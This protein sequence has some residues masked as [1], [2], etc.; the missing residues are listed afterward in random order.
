MTVSH[1]SDK[2]K[3]PSPILRWSLIGGGTVSLGLGIAGTI[4][5][6]LPTT[7][8]LLLSAACYARSSQR[9]YAWLLNHRVFGQIIHTWQAHRRMPRSAKRVALVLI[10]CTFAFSTWMLLERPG[11]W[12]PLDA[13]GMGLFVWILR[14]PVAQTRPTI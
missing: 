14:I 13:F 11:I 10:P 4:V 9:C 1:L 2:R 8:F 12:I 6:L 3:S 5:P 7:P